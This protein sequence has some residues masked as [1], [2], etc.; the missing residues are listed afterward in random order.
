MIFSRVEQDPTNYYATSIREK[1][2]NVNN[3]RT[4]SVAEERN[5]PMRS[6]RD[7]QTVDELN[8]L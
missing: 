2:D 3:E 1:V 8:E 5:L 4:M 7:G 6:G